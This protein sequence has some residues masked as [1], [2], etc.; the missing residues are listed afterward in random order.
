MSNILQFV[1]AYSLFSSFSNWAGPG[2]K[3]FNMKFTDMQAQ[4]ASQYTTK[5]KNS[6]HKRYRHSYIYMYIYIIVNNIDNF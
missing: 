4:L 3:F 5:I 6:K 2:L 1:R